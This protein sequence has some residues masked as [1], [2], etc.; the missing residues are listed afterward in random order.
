VRFFGNTP[1]AARNVLEDL[2]LVVFI[3]IVGIN[4]GGVL[5][6]LSGELAAKILVAGFVTSVLPPVL[7][8][9]VGYHVMKMNPAILMGG[10]AGARSHSSPAREAAGEI[11]SS[12]PWVGFPVAYAVSG[13]LLTAFGYVAMILSR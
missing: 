10:I 8:W 13:I 5:A 6:N 12:V 9:A 2:G 4:A 11:G 3:A 1:N 7:A